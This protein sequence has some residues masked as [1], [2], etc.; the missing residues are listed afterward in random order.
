[1]EPQIRY[2]RTSDGVRIA[3]YAMG[4]GPA[5]V[6]TSEVQWSHL[7]TTM[8]FKEHYRSNSPGGL[9]R[10]LQVVRYDTRGT[11]LSDRS[12]T[13]FSLDAQTRDLLAVVDAIKLE[14]FALFGNAH[15]TP[16]AI[17][18]A[19]VHPHRVSHLVLSVPYARGR[20]LRPLSEN[21]GLRPVAE[22]SPQQWV[23]FT[24][25]LANAALTFSSLSLAESV[26]R[27]YR[28]AMTPAAYAA[29][30]SWREEVDVSEFLPRITV[31][32][33]VLSRRSSTRP[34]LEVEVAGSIPNA[35]LVTVD[36]DQRIPDF[37]LPAQTEAVEQ[38]LDVEP[39][40]A[41]AGSTNTLPATLTARELEVLALLVGGRSNR[42]IADAL[43]LSERTVARHIANIYEKTGAHG[44]AEITAYAL[45][46]RLA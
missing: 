23:A 11:G 5:L 35:R 45:R 33:L 18:F 40:T 37:W 26:A 24:Q 13:D 1:M 8:G 28:Q 7:G 27:N 46:H 21:L 20:D 10:G 29:M 15:G 30:L 39:A 14:R 22:M 4:E 31:P 2:A 25:T 17:A 34:L 6:V 19:A 44:R 16:L 41:G 3:Y 36:A 32:T 42:E 38:F 9:G 12:Y 43:V